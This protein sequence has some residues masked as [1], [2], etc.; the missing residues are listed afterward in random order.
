M[1]EIISKK[2]VVEEKFV[3]FLTDFEIEFVSLVDHGANRAPFKI[4][5]SQTPFL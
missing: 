3:E 5:R 2:E 4:I 1:G